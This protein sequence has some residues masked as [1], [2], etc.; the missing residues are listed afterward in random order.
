MQEILFALV[1]HTG[2]LIAETEDSFVLNGKID[3]LSEAEKQIIER[4]A[5]VGFYCKRLADFSGS[6]RQRHF[7][8]TLQAPSSHLPKPRSA[9]A[10]ADAKGAAPLPCPGH[11]LYALS[12]RVEDILDAYRGRVVALEAEVLREPSLPLAHVEGAIEDDRRVL[13]VLHALVRKIES[14]GLFGGPLLDFLWASAAGYAGMGSVYECLWSVV[15]SAGQVF[16]NQLVGWMVY[17]RLLDP[18][19]DFFIGRGWDHQPAWEPGTAL[20]GVNIDNFSVGLDAAVAQR[21]WQS[22]FFLRPEEVPQA[23]LSLETAKKVLFVG[24]AVRVLIR[25]KRWL[26]SA[27]GG[28]DVAEVLEGSLDPPEVQEEVDALRSCF[29]AKSPVHVVERSV[30]RIRASAALQLRQLVVEEASLARHLLA[31]KGFYLLGYGDFYQTFLEE[32]HSLLS[33]RPPPHAEVALAHGPW[34]AAMGELETALE[35]SDVGRATPAH[36][37]SSSK[38]WRKLAN[39]FEMRFVPNQ[40]ELQS[41][42]DCARQVKLVGMARLA[43]G[44]AELGLGQGDGTS[45]VGSAAQ[46]AMLWLATR[47]RV[48]R[49]FGHSF[50]FQL[51]APALGS[52]TVAEYGCRF[53]WCCQ[54]RWAPSDLQRWKHLSGVGILGFDGDGRSSSN[55]AGSRGLDKTMPCPVWTSLGECLAVEVSFSVIPSA[56]PGDPMGEITLAA[57]VCHPG[58]GDDSSRRHGAEGAKGARLPLV[59]KL[60]MGTVSLAA[61]RGKVHTVRLEYA[62]SHKLLQIFFG[63]ESTEPVCTAEV[64]FSEVLSLDLGSAHLGLCLLP[65]DHRHRLARS[66]GDAAGAAGSAAGGGE[67]RYSSRDR[68]VSITSWAHDVV[69][70]PDSEE[71]PGRRTAEESFGLDAWFSSMELS[72]RVPWPLPLVITQSCMERYNRLFKLL[73]AFRH[74]HL[75]LQGAEL[76][77]GELLAWALRSELSYFVSQVLMYFQQ[78]VIESAHR[79]LLRTVEASKDFDLV[80]CAHEEFLATV[81]AHCFLRSPELH[82]ALMAALRIAALFCRLATAPVPAPPAPSS[83]RAAMRTTTTLGTRGA[84]LRRLQAEFTSTVRSVLRMMSSMHR[85]GMHSHLSQ[86]LLRLDY[87]GYFSGETVD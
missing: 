69:S 16:A 22:V 10:D 30:E 82:D 77:R 68:P 50:S 24:K 49:S 83:G 17:G 75:E 67:A 76:P 72:Y 46:S 20:Y 56:G 26:P 32:A 51:H 18:H 34:A 58:L 27:M 86:L 21:E 57:Y 39:R 64:D 3:Y 54:H 15:S 45:G 63:I 38:R 36:S 47:Q 84:E 44:T 81:T 79:K 80:V 13:H 33:H 52:T 53:A 61:P 62:S 14:K 23:V 66:P 9:A 40:F 59:H 25:S 41:F 48:A 29:D 5:R 11:C 42:N 78:D 65:L 43:G 73:L 87:N 71:S 4:I 37:A 74:V 1:G 7:K 12:R 19:G 6:V 70:G 85:L 60:A 31:L 2:G 8:S 35:A 55:L 28:Q